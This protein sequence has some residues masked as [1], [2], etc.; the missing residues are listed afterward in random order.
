MWTQ[1]PV[2]NVAAC[3]QRCLPLIIP[4]PVWAC[5]S[6][7]EKWSLSPMPLESGWLCDCFVNQQNMIEM[8]SCQCWASSWKEQE[9]SIS[10]LWKASLTL[11]CDSPETSRLQEAQITWRWSRRGDVLGQKEAT[12]RHI[13][14]SDNQPQPGSA[15]CWMQPREWVV[16]VRAA[17]TKEFP[18]WAHLKF[19]AHK[20]VSKRQL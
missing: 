8:T 5:H 9:A 15:T 7:T 10:S 6:L 13:M 17:R 3:S 18:S 4:R 2:H 19:L 12:W 16:P 20:I 14:L 11:K 1:S